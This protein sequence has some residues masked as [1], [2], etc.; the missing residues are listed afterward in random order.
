MNDAQ[1]SAG[2]VRFGAFEFNPEVGELLKHG[3][4][5]KLSGQPV[6]LLA[7]LLERPG[8]LVTRED[9][10]KRLWPHDTVVEFEH[11]INAAI[12]R[13][14]EALG[15]SADEPRYVETLPRRGYRFIGTVDTAA[16]ASPQGKPVRTDQRPAAA[17]PVGAGDT[18]PGTLIGKEVSHYRVTGE[19]GRGGMGVVYKAEDL[20]LGRPVALKFLPEELADDRKFLERFRREAR[21]AS[22][23]NHPNICTIYDI[24]EHAGQPFIVMEYLEGETLKEKIVGADVVPARGR[25]QGLP[26]GLDTLLD[27]ATQIADGLENAHAQGIIHRD[28][29]P[30]NIFVTSRGQA[31]I[32]DF[33]L[34]K[35]LPHAR[36]AE[37]LTSDSTHG[38]TPLTQQGTPAGSM[39][40]MSPEPARAEALDTR[41]D[42]FSF[43]AV[44]YEMATGRRAFAGETLAVIFDAILNRAPTSPNRLNPKLPAQLEE[45]IAKALEKDREIRYQ[46]AAELCADLKRLKNNPESGRVVAPVYARRQETP[47]GKGHSKRRRLAIALASAVLVVGAAIT[48]WF[49]HRPPPYAPMTERRLTTNS[50]ENPVNQGSISPDGKY[51]AYSDMTGIHLKNVQT[52][53][54]FDVPQPA[55]PAPSPS[56][57]WPSGWFPDSTKVLAT[58]VEPGPHYSAWVISVLGGL[59]RKLCDN[60]SAWSVS[61]DGS[62]ILIKKA[63]GID[64]FG[65]LAVMG[66]Q[67]EEPHTLVARS[68]DAI[69]YQ[70]V[71]SPDGQRVAYDIIR[72]TPH[73]NEHSIESRDLK[74][75]HPS[76]I[77]SD[78]ET[79]L[80]SFWWFPNGHFV[81]SKA[82]PTFGPDRA[83]LWEVQVNPSTGAPVG[84][85]RQITHWEEGYANYI[86]GTADGKQLAVTKGGAYAYVSVGELEAGGRRLKNPRRLTLEESWDV[87]SGWMPDSK[88]LLF[89][90]TRNETS[91]LYKQELDQTTAQPIVIGPDFKECP[92]ASPDG[93]WILYLSHPSPPH[94]DR[95]MRVPALG[96]APQLVLEQQGIS[97]LGC[98][99]S[100]ADSCVFSEES[101]DR[102]QL[103]FFGVDPREGKAKELTRIPLSQP[104]VDYGWDVSP[105]GSRVALG[106]NEK[107]EGRIQILPLAGG[108]AREIKVK[109]W[110][111]LETLFWAAD[112][113][114]L[115]VSPALAQGATLLHVD[116]KGHAQVIW[117][118]KWS[119]VFGHVIGVPSPDG[120]HLAISAQ[121]ENHNV[122]LLESF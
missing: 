96:G 85:L 94:H 7:M 29:K 93:A 12:N 5:I 23:L 35:R 91:S 99:R 108:Q 82:E 121:S 79:G 50:G 54:I 68:Q 67:G 41:T 114:G 66:A 115:F 75:G 70:A 53:E 47:R 109:D 1:Q 74:G 44:L 32:L 11:S 34:A 55:G 61:P 59:P 52:G 81:Y 86:N 21:A 103:I 111:G 73:G 51:L 28:I 97:Q 119:G 36:E 113:R 40:Y 60:A 76:V 10:Q 14:R 31:K 63:P 77:V 16:E 105:D 80:F 64:G 98:P 8:Q 3:L 49:T 107:G 120:R 84:E 37:G 22:A 112:C 43:G 18:E 122:W 58:G 48:Y 88:T 57:W 89:W 42:L 20:Q 110:K 15:D 83:N 78:P 62:L 87:P 6:E 27:L 26:L 104:V 2:R 39:E 9:L 17:E 24:G 65:D 116:L 100:P 56:S 38:E 13:L 72:H 118:Q 106:Q 92:V 90:S 71:W 19:L 4:K 45:I 95:I 101:A 25:R 33:G 30:A 69:P 102:K 117:Q 46:H